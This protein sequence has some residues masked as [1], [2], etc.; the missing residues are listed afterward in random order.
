PS[1]PRHPP[2][3]T[4]LAVTR[5]WTLASASCPLERSGHGVDVRG[6]GPY[7]PTHS[8]CGPLHPSCVHSPS[9]SFCHELTP[10]PRVDVL[11]SHS[12]IRPGPRPRRSVVPSLIPH[13]SSRSRPPPMT[14]A[15]HAPSHPGMGYPAF[16]DPT[17]PRRGRV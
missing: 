16:V 7:R 10:H 2:H 12:L 9:A 6:S 14:I 13:P 3:R 1:Q 11:P 8:T 15:Y 5:P 4:P 17:P